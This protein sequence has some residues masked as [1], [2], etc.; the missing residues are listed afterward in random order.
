IDQSPQ[1]R[2][3]HIARAAQIRDVDLVAL[4]DHELA[5]H[6]AELLEFSVGAWNL[7]FLFHGIGALML[8][9]LAFTCRDLLGWDDARALT[10][11]AGLSKAS[12]EPADVLAG[13]TAMAAERPAVR[14]FIEQGETDVARLWDI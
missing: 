4:D 6:L 7:H 13:V 1:W 12:S 8:A 10:L 5:D 9:D 2:A 14:R 3:A 11:L